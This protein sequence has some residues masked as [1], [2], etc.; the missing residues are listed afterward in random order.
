M[1]CIVGNMFQMGAFFEGSSASYNKVLSIANLIFTAIFAVEA[2]LKLTAFKLSYFKN[3]WN[4]FDFTVVIASLFD[5]MMG[6][7]S[8][9]SMKALRVGP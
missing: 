1:T 3:S 2:T 8:E 5:I 9:T 4:R 6:L 7:M